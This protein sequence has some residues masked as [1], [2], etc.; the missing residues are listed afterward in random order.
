VVAIPRIFDHALKGQ[1]HHARHGL[2]TRAVSAHICLVDLGQSRLESQPLSRAP[3]SGSF[4]DR[5]LLS[6]QRAWLP[7]E[8]ACADRNAA[9]RA[10]GA[11][12]LGNRK[13]GAVTRTSPLIISRCTGVRRQVRNLWNKLG[14]TTGFLRHS[15][16][17]MLKN[18]TAVMCPPDTRI[19]VRMS[20]AVASC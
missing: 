18:K 12:W 3:S 13:D 14:T 19:F 8:L 16:A 17:N 11:R 1:Y 7:G 5:P 2:L 15:D 20:S 4:R 10:P 9:L 6:P